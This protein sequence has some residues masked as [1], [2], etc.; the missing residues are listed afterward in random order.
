MEPKAGLFGGACKLYILYTMKNI[1]KYIGISLLLIIAFSSCDKNNNLALFSVQNDKDL[2][3]QVSAEIAKDPGTYPVVSR[4]EYAE[5]YEYFDAMV[6]EILDNGEVVY[7][8]EFAWEFSIIDNDSVLNAFAAPG[9]YIYVYTGLI[10]F[11]DSADDLAGVLGHEIAHADLRHTSRNLQRQFGVQVLLGVLLGED[12]KTLTDIAGGLAGLQFSRTFETE[13]DIRAVEYN[14]NTEYACDG[15]KNFF[16]KLIDEEKVSGTPQFLSTH[17]NPDNRVA[18]ITA[19]AE[20]E[21]CDTEPSGDTG[22]AKFKA[23]LP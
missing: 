8:E 13:A 17:P 10:K 7:R 14:A 2:G 9:G 20:E 16:Q 19:K 6:N 21:N 11:L 12:S 1:I 4:T 5:A 23:D 22:Y 3:A 18:D 15:V